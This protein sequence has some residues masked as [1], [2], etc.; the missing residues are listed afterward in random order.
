[1]PAIIEIARNVRLSELEASGKYDK[2]ILE[3]LKDIQSEKDE[4]LRRNL[5]NSIA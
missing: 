5:I 2:K 1:M 4:T 3:E